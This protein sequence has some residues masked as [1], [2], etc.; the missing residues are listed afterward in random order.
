[1]LVAVTTDNIPMKSKYLS[2]KEK[3]VGLAEYLKHSTYNGLGINFLAN[4][5]VYLMAIHYGASNLQLGYISSVI[6]LSGVILIFL[7]KLIN[8]LNLVKVHYYAWVFRGLI[9]IFYGLLFFTPDRNAVVLILKVYTAF[10]LIRTVGIP[11]GQP[12]Q[13]SLTSQNSIGEFVAKLLNR[14]HSMNLLSNTISFIVLSAKFFETITGLIFIQFLGVAANAM[15]SHHIKKVPCRE[16]VVYKSGRNIFFLL[17]KNLTKREPATVLIIHW[18]TLSSMIL[19]SFSIPFLRKIIM[20]PDNMVF[21]YSFVASLAAVFS[22]YLIKPFVDRIGSRP[23]MILS[24]AFLAILSLGWA[25]IPIDIPW[26]LIFLLSFLTLFSQGLTVILAGRLMLKMIPEK[27]KI[28]YTSMVHFF[29]AIVALVLGLFGG[30]LIN[31]GEVISS[32][33]FHDYSLVFLLLGISALG[34]IVSSYFL[35]DRGSLSVRE[36][37][38]ILLSTRNLKAYLD[39]YQFNLTSNPVKKKTILLAIGDSDTNVATEEIR[40]I[41]KNPLSAEK[42]EILKSLFARPRKV[43]LDEIVQEAS[44]VHSYHRSQAIFALGAYPNTKVEQALIAFL[45]DTSPDIRSS[46]AKSLARVG[47]VSKLE[48]VVKLSKSPSNKI[49]ERMNFFIAISIMD[50]SGRYLSELFKTAATNG[51]D[52]STQAILSLSSRLLEMSPPLSEI[53]QLENEQSLKGVKRLLDEAKEIQIFN[54]QGKIIK[55]D[56]ASGDFVNIFEW[57]CSILA[58]VNFDDY[59]KH[60]KN[61]IV[62]QSPETLNLSTAL[63]TLYFTYQTLKIG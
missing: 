27:D 33:H 14:F 32:S 24:S 15:A 16:S 56:F 17:K 39:L 38:Q 25:F 36:T 37:T 19:M 22:G 5:T 61:S 35:E 10:C 8:G 9:C 40:R 59:R 42:G 48:K 53:Y 12:I 58:D 13:Q 26:G 28:T 7:P 49:W 55:E 34:I 29:S 41:L 18:L 31:L 54:K 60:L 62:S 20:M 47:N 30:Y 45:D 21:A 6:H 63:A 52:S 57:C 44:D 11:L 3:S 50:K 23:I 43:L 4:T 2:Q 1:M 46:A 51:G